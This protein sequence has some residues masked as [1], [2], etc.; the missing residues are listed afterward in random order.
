MINVKKYDDRAADINYSHPLIINGRMVTHIILF[1]GNKHLII[2][3]LSH[4]KNNVLFGGV[5]FP[6]LCVILIFKQINV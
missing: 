6:S 2:F 4:T 5:I 3:I 1:K